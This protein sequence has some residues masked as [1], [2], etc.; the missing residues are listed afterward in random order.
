[1]SELNTTAALSTAALSS[2]VGFGLAFYIAAKINKG[3]LSKSQKA[4]VYVAMTSF[5]LGLTGVLNEFVGFPLQGLRVRGDKVAQHILGIFVLPAIFLGLAYV[6]ERRMRQSEKGRSNSQAVNDQHSNKRLSKNL[7]LNTGGA[8]LAG[9]LLYLG[10]ELTKSNATYDFYERVDKNDCTSTFFTLK[11][12]VSFS[13]S[14]KKETSD[15]FMTAEY[16][17]N[18]MKKHEIR[19]LDN[20]TVLDS[21]NWTCGGEWIKS[22]RLPQYSMVRGELSFSDFT[23][24]TYN[25]K[26][27]KR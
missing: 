19:K 8:I 4:L 1:M 10:I 11:P 13:F 7:K 17:T 21:K 23:N 9:L 26:I 2:A 22:H 25:Y 3:M 18:G 14:L 15:I 27:V 6:L 5:G 12:A 16:E 20:C 24:C